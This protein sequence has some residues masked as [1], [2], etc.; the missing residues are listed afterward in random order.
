MYTHTYTKIHIQIHTPHMHACLYM[1][2]YM[3]I[4]MGIQI[5]IHTSET[6]VHKHACTH[7]YTCHIPA[8]TAGVVLLIMRRTE[9]TTRVKDLQHHCL[10]DLHLE[11]LENQRFLPSSTPTCSHSGPPHTQ[12]YR[13]WSTLGTFFKFGKLLSHQ[14][15]PVNSLP[16]HPREPNENRP[17]AVHTL[18]FLNSSPF[19]KTL[20][21]QSIPR[22][23]HRSHDE[24]PAA[25]VWPQAWLPWPGN[26]RSSDHRQS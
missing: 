21:H 3:H 24:G 26:W 25:P 23:T 8:D 16:P 2:K 4:Y 11:S 20:P 12:L 18:P 17:N 13:L 5:H 6:R 10:R 15:D 19:P 7:T 9:R 22:P 1:Y 14:C